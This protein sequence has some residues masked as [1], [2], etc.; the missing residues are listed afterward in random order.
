[1]YGPT[2]RSRFELTSHLGVDS[3]AH[4]AQDAEEGSRLGGRVGEGTPFEEIGIFVRTRGQSERMEAALKLAGFDAIG[5]KSGHSEAAAEV[6][7]VR[8]NTR[9]GVARQSGQFSRSSDRS[10]VARSDT[11]LGPT[12][13]SS[14]DG[15]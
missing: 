3:A 9:A 2:A 4:Q 1:M 8:P 15:E 14:K 7:T 13:R 12:V 6:T 10:S 5:P 11:L